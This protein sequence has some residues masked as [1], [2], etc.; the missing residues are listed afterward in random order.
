MELFANN[1]GTLVM[2]DVVLAAK[3]SFSLHCLLESHCNMLAYLE[4]KK[5][6]F[7]GNVVIY[8]LDLV[9]LVL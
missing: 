4:A 6:H 9:N 3:S 7:L 1:I 5:Q 2:F 8:I